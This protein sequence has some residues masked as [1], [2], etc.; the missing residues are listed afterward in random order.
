MSYLAAFVSTVYSIEV[1]LIVMGM[2][3]A[4]TMI[5]VLVATFSKVVYLFSDAFYYFL[6]FLHTATIYA[7]LFLL[8]S[9]LLLFKYHIKNYYYLILM[10]Q[11]QFDLTMR[12][13]LMLII[14]LVAIVAIFTVLIILLFTHIMVL[15]LVIA[16]IGTLLLCLVHIFD[17]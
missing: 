4:V 3:A 9:S 12:P 13:G 15:R 11:P 8:I 5:I 17:F 14:G 2:T 7:V 1:I 6:R 10:T 16:I